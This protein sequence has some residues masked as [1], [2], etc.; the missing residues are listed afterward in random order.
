MCLGTIKVAG[1]VVLFFLMVLKF[2]EICDKYAVEPPSSSSYIVV[3]HQSFLSWRTWK[4]VLLSLREA[5][6][7]LKKSLRTFLRPPEQ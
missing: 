3:Y 7:E 6:P 2:F 5:E 1:I 4:L